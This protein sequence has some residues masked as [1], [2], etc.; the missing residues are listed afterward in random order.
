MR[1]VVLLVIA[2]TLALTG[3]LAAPAWAPVEG[4]RECDNWYFNN[5][6]YEY[7]YSHCANPY[8]VQTVVKAHSRH[9]LYRRG[10]STSP[11]SDSPN[12]MLRIDVWNLIVRSTNYPRAMQQDTDGSATADFYSAGI[13]LACLARA[14][15]QNVGETVRLSN[16]NLVG[17]NNGAEEFVSSYDFRP[18]S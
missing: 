9:H 1:R 11:W 2:L 16:G 17:G 15:A 3:L 7:R 8:F 13:G 10:D 18:C 6:G 12:Q 4:R 5:G 14:E